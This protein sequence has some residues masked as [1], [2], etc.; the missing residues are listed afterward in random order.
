MKNFKDGKGMYLKI[1]DLQD[2]IKYHLQNYIEKEAIDI[3]NYEEKLYKPFNK[4]S[5]WIFNELVEGSENMKCLTDNM[6]NLDGDAQII[7][8]FIQ[9]LKKWRDSQWKI[10]M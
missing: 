1:I 9:A 3:H 4:V 5:E 10:T 7:T 2:E 6:E 8:A